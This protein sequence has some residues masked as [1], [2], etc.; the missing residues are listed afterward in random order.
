[1]TRLC[2][3]HRSF[4]AFYYISPFIE[5]R[6]SPFFSEMREALRLIPESAKQRLRYCE[7]STALSAV[8][9]ACDSSFGES[10]AVDS[11]GR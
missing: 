8:F 4:I 7:S 5:L 1:M 2:N 11:E 10:R 6:T 9:A 3:N